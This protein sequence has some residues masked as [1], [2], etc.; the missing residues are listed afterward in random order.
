MSG[1]SP[2]ESDNAMSAMYRI[3]HEDPPRLP[4]AGAAIDEGDALFGGRIPHNGWCI[5]QELLSGSRSRFR[6]HSMM[7]LRS[8]P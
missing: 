7:W 8:K 6:I 1:R 3:V 4:D 5:N 2:Y